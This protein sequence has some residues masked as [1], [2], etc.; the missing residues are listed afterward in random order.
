ME[1]ASFFSGAGG[2]DLGFTNAGFRLVFANDNWK[3]CQKTFEENHKV[4]LDTRPI[5]EITHEEIPEVVGFVGGPPCQS[6]SIAGA[7]RGSSD[8]RGQSFFDYISLVKNKKPLFFLAENVAGIVSK[9]H[10]KEFEKIL[11]QFRD[12]YDVE[13][14]LLNTR[15]FGVPQDR[16][17]VI[18]IGYRK[19]LN[20]K[21]NFDNLSNSKIITLREAIGDLPEN[22]VLVKKNRA[23][24]NLNIP[25]HEH[26][27]AGF[28]SQFLSRNRRRSWEEPSFTIQAQVRQAPIHPSSDEMIKKGP[29]EWV[30]KGGES[31][32]H[33]RFSVRECARIQTFPDEFVF[34]YKFVS[35]GYKMIGNAVPVKFAEVLANQ[36]KEDLKDFLKIGND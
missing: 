10:V 6:W 8:P 7:M 29:D 27:D 28:S 11:D 2:L 31:A 17:R 21:F 22:V 25:N 14:K 33:R 24:D 34:H 36:I 12:E 30:F 16:K 15:D 23:N 13:W 5:A 9:S 19:D 18:V 35:D 4:V 20:K 26:M 1:I 32:K 3:G